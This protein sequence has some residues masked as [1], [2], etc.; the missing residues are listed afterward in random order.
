MYLD[1]F[2]EGYSPRIVFWMGCVFATF[3]LL[4]WGLVQ[5]QLDRY[6]E[7]TKDISR[8]SVR[9]VRLNPTRGKILTSDGVLIADSRRV[10]D[11]VFHVSEM[12]QPGRLGKTLDH[13]LKQ[14][15]QIHQQLGRDFEIGRA[16]LLKHLN[17]RPALPFVIC[18]ELTQQE[19]GMAS[20]LMHEYPGMGVEINYRRSYP[21][22][23]FASH[24]LGYT[25]KRKPETKDEEGASFFYVKPELVGRDGLERQYDEL[26]AGRPGAKLLLVDRSGYVHETLDEGRPPLNGRDLILTLDS[27]AQWAAQTA[28]DNAPG[29]NGAM[30]ILNCQTGA[31]LAMASKPGYEPGQIPVRGY[32]QSLLKDKR[33]PLLNRSI[34][35]QYEPGS[36]IKP[37]MGLVALEGGYLQPDEEIFCTGKSHLGSKRVAGKPRC[38]KRSGHGP[39]DILA[40]LAHS[41]NPFFVDLG[42]VIGLDNIAPFYASCGVGRETGIDLPGEIDGMLPDRSLPKRL[43]NRSWTAYNTAQISIGQGF[44]QMTPLQAAV[45]TAALA[46]GGKLMRPHLLDEVRSPDDNHLVAEMTPVIE[47]KIAANPAYIELARE[48]MR[49]VVWRATGTARVGREAPVTIAGKTGTAQIGDDKNNTWFICFGP[50]E[51][52]EFAVAVLI[53]DGK[54]GG[55]TAAPVAVEALNLWLNEDED[56]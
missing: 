50:Y 17:H 55:S 5:V 45:Y 34:A 47:S 44:F 36:I 10:F 23:N 27:R 41:C 25:G 28:L 6:E 22:E 38:W 9:R 1:R 29:E 14:A 16:D 51:K 48:G 53:E 4:F 43:Y 31:V 39:Q 20:E 35:S 46:N 19:L 8:Q 54:S 40:A 32:Y 3:G 11:L 33:L 18:P 42:Q 13:L 37:M 21:V 56:E 26:L 2:F 52:P 24:L 15:E 30:V 7:L 49:Q 12:R